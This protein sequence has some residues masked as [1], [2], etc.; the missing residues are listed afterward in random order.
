M[1]ALRGKLAWGFLCNES[2]W[3][4][5]ARSRYSIGRRGSFLWKSISPFI[6]SIA[7]DCQ[8]RLGNGNTQVKI[9]CQNIAMPFPKKLKSIA[10]KD[11]LSNPVYRRAFMHNVHPRVSLSLSSPIDNNHV[12]QLLW[13]K[14]PSGVVTTKSFW[15]FFAPPSIKIPK[16]SIIWQS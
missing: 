9:F 11:V 4:K 12:D 16:F 6:S 15:N 8:W 14:D 5:H 7:S 10:I 3:A 1:I 2:L 13:C